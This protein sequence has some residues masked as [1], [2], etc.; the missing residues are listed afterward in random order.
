MAASASSS[1]TSLS[2]FS[3]LCS[4]R[5]KSTFFG[6]FR[7][8]RACASSCKGGESLLG[9]FMH[10]CL[11]TYVFPYVC[12]YADWQPGWQRLHSTSQRSFNARALSVLLTRTGGAIYQE[13]VRCLRLL[14]YM[15]RPTL[16][17]ARTGGDEETKFLGNPGRAATVLSSLQWCC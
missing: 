7:I 10:S 17:Q 9:L 4:I 8:H 5:G 16:T 2:F 11:A 14:L 12:T 13:K 1:G 3:L 6:D 15:T